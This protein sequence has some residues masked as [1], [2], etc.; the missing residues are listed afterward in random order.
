MTETTFAVVIVTLIN[1]VGSVIMTA[2]RLYYRAHYN[3]GEF[4]KGNGYH[5][6]P[7][8]PERKLP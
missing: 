1:M 6:D 5:V 3:T 7:P 4:G 8:K 2:L